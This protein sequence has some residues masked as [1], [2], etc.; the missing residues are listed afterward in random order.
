MT[1]TVGRL[2]SGIMLLVRCGAARND[3]EVFVG[4]GGPLQVLACDPLAEP[5]AVVL[6]AALVAASAELPAV[7]VLV[8][9][10][11]AS[12]WLVGAV[13]L[14]VPKGPSQC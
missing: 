14:A 1:T 2:C 13:V 9:A 10:A 12:R 8:V 4:A 11:S 5:L 3:G 7:V 6:C